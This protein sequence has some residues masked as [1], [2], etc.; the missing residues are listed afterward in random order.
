VRNNT[1]DMLD[2]VPANQMRVHHILQQVHR[3]RKNLLVDVLLDNFVENL[4]VHQ[5]AVEFLF[6]LLVLIRS[7]RFDEFCQK[8]ESYQILLKV[9]LQVL[10]C[11]KFAKIIENL[12][13]SR[14]RVKSRTNV[15]DEMIED[16][17][18]IAI[19]VL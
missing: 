18:S 15:I 1:P 2:L 12:M 13:F 10:N 11:Q 17:K 16:V 19:E 6:L 3:P 4:A 8:L 5:I 9:E 14:E 7:K